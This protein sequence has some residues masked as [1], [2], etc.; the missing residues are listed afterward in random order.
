MKRTFAKKLLDSVETLEVL[1]AGTLRVP[2]GDQRLTTFKSARPGPRSDRAGT[3]GFGR[4]ALSILLPVL[5]CS[6]TLADDARAW[7]ELEALSKRAE[8]IVTYAAD[9]RQEKFTPLLRD[10]IESH[11]R[12]RIV[13]SVSRW[14]TEAPYASTMLLADGELRLHY[15]EQNTLEVY[16]LGD[17]LDALAA[18][19]VP[20]LDVLRQNFEIESS[21]WTH[22]DKLFTLTLLPK[23]EQLR[24]ALEEVAVDIDPALGSLRR[25]SMT[26][27]DGETTVI[28]FENI[29]LNPDLDPADLQLDVPS[30]TKVVR[31]LE[32]VG[33]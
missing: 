28:H 8:P 4:R 19:P 22:G 25:L 6:P 26:D 15:P 16:E 9:F 5:A 33:G 11:G 23:T 32:A 17:R 29:Q 12:V 10:P 20:D 7:D 13:E 18:S 2:G 27:L 3:K 24:D 1:I 21:E 30:G 14:D 31:P